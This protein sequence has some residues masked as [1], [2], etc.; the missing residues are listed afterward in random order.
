[1]EI[2][3]GQI[4]EAISKGAE[5]SHYKP[6]D[7]EIRP[8]FLRETLVALLTERGRREE[9]DRARE[10]KKDKDNRSAKQRMIDLHKVWRNSDPINHAAGAE[11]V[12][13]MEEHVDAIISVMNR[14]TGDNPEGQRLETLI[15][16]VKKAQH[17]FNPGY[18]K[19][20]WC[21]L[22][23]G[24]PKPKDSVHSEGCQMIFNFFAEEG[25]VSR[26]L[27]PMDRHSPPE[28]GTKVSYRRNNARANSPGVPPLEGESLLKTG[29]VYTV[30][31]NVQGDFRTGI[32]LKEIKGEGLGRQLFDSELFNI[33][34]EDEPKTEYK[35]RFGRDGRYV[36]KLEV[37]VVDLMN[38]LT[39]EGYLPQGERTIQ[40]FMSWLDHV[41]MIANR[42]KKRITNQKIERGKL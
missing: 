41:R 22:K 9:E 25:I 31:G 2:T 40:K 6:E 36:E 4:D 12:E 23:K 24:N 18:G 14:A 38:I 39:G 35:V 26:T 16:A 20:C 28:A 30:D 11:L 5:R 42:I 33:I 1:M 34:L 37:E 29:L 32:H 7:R 17:A 21:S 8:L 10:L 15:K 3:E 27:I 19:G 13:L